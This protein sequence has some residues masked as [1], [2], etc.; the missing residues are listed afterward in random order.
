MAKAEAQATLPVLRAGS[1]YGSKFNENG[2]IEPVA[3]EV[4]R[5]TNASKSRMN[6]KP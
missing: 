2:V 5:K 4:Q 1:W 3:F 6:P